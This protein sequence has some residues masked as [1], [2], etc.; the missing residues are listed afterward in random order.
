MLG[1]GNTVFNWEPSFSLPEE[2]ETKG[3]SNT[4]AWTV[5]GWFGLSRCQLQ[6]LWPSESPAREQA[7]DLTTLYVPSNWGQAAMVSELGIGQSLAAP[8]Y[9]STLRLSTEA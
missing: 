4:K 9:R 3:F 1:V 2:C 7:Q 6:R 8:K 5:Y